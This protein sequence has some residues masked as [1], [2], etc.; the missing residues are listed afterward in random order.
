MNS[1]IRSPNLQIWSFVR[2]WLI[3]RSGKLFREAR[4]ASPQRQNNGSERKRRAPPR[5]SRQ[6][7]FSKSLT[8]P[9][10]ASE[11]LERAFG[12][13]D[14]PDPKPKPSMIL[15]VA[16]KMARDA[17]GR[18]SANPKPEKVLDVGGQGVGMPLSP[19]APTT[20]GVE[21][22]LHLGNP[23]LK[24]ERR[25]ASARPQQLHWC[26]RRVSPAWRAKAPRVAFLCNERG[27]EL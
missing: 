18:V 6:K 21:G 8:G 5:L 16:K 15:R 24:A 22:A 20:P 7:V 12:Q 19:R 13:P 3:K 2:F 9:T 27:L 26:W 25:T 11:R 1:A 17:P 14:R 23:K 4:R 10:P